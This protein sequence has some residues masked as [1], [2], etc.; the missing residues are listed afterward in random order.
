MYCIFRHIW[1]CSYDYIKHNTTAARGKQIARPCLILSI[2][3][4][5]QAMENLSVT[6]KSSCF[7]QWKKVFNAL[8]CC[9]CAFS[10][11]AWN[12]TLFWCACLPHSESI[13]QFHRHNPWWWCH[14]PCHV[15]PVPLRCTRHVNGWGCHWWHHFLWHCPQ[16]RWLSLSGHISWRCVPLHR[17]WRVTTCSADGRNPVQRKNRRAHRCKPCRTG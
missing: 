5:K 10:N 1:Q 16:H 4:K 7:Y 3:I 13:R 17:D 6:D 11:N 15:S 12:I 9:F 14:Y 8:A 2:L